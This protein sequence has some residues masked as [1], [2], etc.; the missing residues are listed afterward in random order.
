VRSQEAANLGDKWLYLRP[1]ARGTM[2]D[3]SFVPSLGRVV[4]AGGMAM[5]A[6]S[7]TFTPATAGADA[8]SGHMQ[9][10]LWALNLRLSHEPLRMDVNSA[11][12][13]EL[14][15]V[16]GIQRRQALRIIAE[17][18]YATL[19]ELSRAGMSPGAIVR[20]EPFLTVSH[21]SPSA[22]PAMPAPARPR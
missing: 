8:R 12:V 6:A 11:T 5:I 4:V 21:D 20:V 3:M 13:A 14:S 22:L 18:P 16:P 15:D 19:G 2:V 9:L 1:A 17:R 7:L 10:L